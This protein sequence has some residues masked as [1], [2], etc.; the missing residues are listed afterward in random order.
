MCTVHTGDFLS[1]ACTLH[2]DKILA[3]PSGWLETRPYWSL[4]RERPPRAEHISNLAAHHLRHRSIE[5]WQTRH[6]VDDLLHC[7]PEDQTRERAAAGTFSSNVH[8]KVHCACRLGRRSALSLWRVVLL[9]LLF[10]SP[11]HVLSP[12]G[13]LVLHLGHGD[14]QTFVAKELSESSLPPL[15]SGT[16]VFAMNLRPHEGTKLRATHKGNTT[17][18]GPCVVVVVVVFDTDCEESCVCPRN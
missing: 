5:N 10:P 3:D 7:V 12:W 16:D 1:S 17:C 8:L 14:A 15:F 6:E 11:G 2:L 13:G 4:R 18:L 9:T